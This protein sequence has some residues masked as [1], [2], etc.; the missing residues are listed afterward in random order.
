MRLADRF[1]L[2][3]FM[4]LKLDDLT[5]EVLELSPEQR[6]RIDEL[7][8]KTSARLKEFE[9]Q[10]MTTETS[11][12]GGVMIK[13]PQIKDYARHKETFHQELGVII[14]APKADFLMQAAGPVW[15]V[16]MSG[17]FGEFPRDIRITPANGGYDVHEENF[18][19]YE[20]GSRHSI[21]NVTTTFQG[22][23]PRRLK[24][25]VELAPKK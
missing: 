8:E 7:L 23:L 21:G 11:D 25:L 3:Y 2:P 24:H 13:I 9:F 12:A 10:N 4:E 14:G 1:T 18:S 6:H 19:I 15:R 16:S 17:D 20:D 5:T 22:E